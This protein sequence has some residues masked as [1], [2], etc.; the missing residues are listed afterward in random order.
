MAY[1]TGGGKGG[2]YGAP[3]YQQPRMMPYG[4]GYN[5]YFRGEIIEEN[6]VVGPNGERLYDQ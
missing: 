1:P 5:P 4:G 6:P 2:G 3:M